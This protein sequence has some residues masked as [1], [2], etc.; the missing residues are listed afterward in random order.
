MWR[1]CRRCSVRARTIKTLLSRHSTLAPFHRHLQ[2]AVKITNKH[3]CFLGQRAPCFTFVSQALY[4]TLAAAMATTDRVASQ[5]L[6]AI[7][8]GLTRVLKEGKLKGKLLEPATAQ[9]PREKKH[10]A[11]GLVRAHRPLCQYRYRR[12]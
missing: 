9:Q 2:Q 7:D 12:Q 4:S 3:S 5:D 1:F 8:F 11:S 6:S 10:R